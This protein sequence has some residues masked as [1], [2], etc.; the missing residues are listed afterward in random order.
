M[1]EQFGDFGNATWNIGPDLDEI[2]CTEL[3]GVWL[4]G[5]IGGLQFNVDGGNL[6]GSSAASGG[7]AGDA[8]FTLSTNPESGTVLGFSLTG[9]TFGPGCGTMVELDFESGV[10]TGIS[11]IVISNSVGG[12][13]P[14][15]YV[16]PPLV[17]GCQLPPY[18]LYV[19][20]EGSVF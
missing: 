1:C 5:A 12:E 6:N 2:G 19:T 16:E 7:D 18:N 14:F 11:G 3:S 17:S 8:A 10:P 13:I 15:Q 4:D 9:A 20:E